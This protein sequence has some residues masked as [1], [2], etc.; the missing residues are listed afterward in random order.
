MTELAQTR[1]SSIATRLGEE[2]DSGLRRR[3]F[4]M[5]EG[6]SMSIPRFA[7]M[8]ELSPVSELPTNAMKF[9]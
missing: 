3:K 5:M 1:R 8:P 2:V 7:I 4:S 9:R 6:R